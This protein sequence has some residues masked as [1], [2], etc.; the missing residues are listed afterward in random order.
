M[1]PEMHK[2]LGE[3]SHGIAS[4]Q[5]Y[6]I[7]PLDAMRDSFCGIPTVEGKVAK[8]LVRGQ[9]V[10]SDSYHERRSNSYAV[11]MAKGD[12]LVAG[13]GMG[14]ILHPILDKENVRTVTVIEKEPDVIALIQPSLP[15]PKLAII[16][17]DIFL[18]KPPKGAKY[19]M[20]YFDIWPDM[21][22][23]NLPEM[24]K[25]HQRFKFY[26]APGAFMDSWCRA[27]I[28]HRV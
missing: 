15:S 21:C 7:T 22:A 6:E 26:K 4:I 11:H 25:L 23:D 17:A 18:W 13:L 27:E 19:D 10:M 3:A 1:F 24:A 5:H 9:L 16:Q 20:I 2:L 14:M 28:K 12:V 8:L